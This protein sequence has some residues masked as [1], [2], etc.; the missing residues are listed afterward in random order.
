MSEELAAVS[1]ISPAPA[2]QTDYNSICAALMQTERGRSFLQ[3]YAKRNRSSDTQLL[4]AAIL[5]IEAVVY[6]E[7]NKLAQPGFRTDLLEMAETITRT[8]AEVAEI[9]SD[10]A[11]PPQSARSDSAASPLPPPPQPRDVFAAAERIRDVT[12]A[13]RGHGF[14]PSTCD[15]LEEL[16]ASILS[17]SSLRDPSDRR[18]SKLS[19]V[20]QYLEHRISMLLESCRDG[21]ASAR[22]PAPEP[23]HHAFEPAPAG[24]A[25]PESGFV[26][27][28][29][30]EERELDAADLAGPA[31]PPSPWTDSR[32]TPVAAQDDAVEG[33]AAALSPPPAAEMAVQE[34]SLPPPPDPSAVDRVEPTSIDGGA[35]AARAQ[36]QGAPVPT[37]KLIHSS[38]SVTKSS[39]IRAASPAL[40]EVTAR[41][42]LSEIEPLFR[43]ER[44]NMPGFKAARAG[45]APPADSISPAPD[46]PPS[47]ASSQDAAA[48]HVQASQ[49]EGL[50]DAEPAEPGTA[51]L[52]A[53]AA[54]IPQ[55]PRGDPLAAL[56]AMSDHE[57]TALFS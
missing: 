9:G 44:S 1:K 8:R 47:P 45:R 11:A 46:P 29:V 20:L 54:P 18:A 10:A 13:M 26:G 12:W 43:S 3:E 57:L 28:F 21:D 23:D 52:R 49:V 35:P 17:A 40:R 51:P 22:E 50:T 7:R 41:S 5:R 14:D 6:A 42:F 34:A 24:K 16:A 25:R 48:E 56:E 55:P 2:A 32:S 31:S 39:R 4:L 30:M 53:A 27:P 38:R 19:E 37:V 36:P 33:D 15:Q